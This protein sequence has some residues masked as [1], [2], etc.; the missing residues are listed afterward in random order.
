MYK[1]GTM[2]L[3]L[4]LLCSGVLYE[5]PVSAKA[6]EARKSAV[7][8]VHRIDLARW[9]IRN[10]GTQPAQATKGIND[11]LAWAGK[12][13]ITAVS[14]PPG[15]YAI[16][17]N[18]RINMVSNMTFQLTPDVILQKEPN[19]KERYDLMYIGYGVHDVTLIGGTYQGDKDM[20]DYSKKDH[21]DSKGTHE[22]GYG[23]L[24][25]G[26]ER[27][28]I[29]GVKAVNFTGDG[30]MLSAHGTNTGVLDAKSFVRG[31]IDSKGKPISDLTKIRTKSLKSLSHEIFRK[32]GY[33]ELANFRGL[34]PNFDIYFYETS[35][36]FLEKR[37]AKMRENMVIPQGAAFYHVVFHQPSA[38]D[39]YLQVWNRVPTSDSVVK[40]SEFAFNRR[41]G[42]TVGG[43]R[44]VTIMDN[45]LHD[46]KG[47]APQSGIDVEGGF[48][49]NGNWNSDVTIKRN[50][51]YNNAAYDL[52]LYDGQGA[53]V[54]DN[55]F[56]ST[57]KFGL[58]VSAPFA[59]AVMVNNHFD[60]S[61]IVAENDAVFTGN[62]M[63]DSV[64]SFLGPNIQVNGMTL[65][66]AVF[67][68]DGKEKFGVKVSELTIY[69]NKKRESGLIVN[70]MPSEFRNVKIIGESTLRVLTG[71]APGGSV[72]HNL[73]VLDYNSTYG[74]SLP[75]GT[76]TDCRFETA[77]TGTL[78][79]VFINTAGKY[80]FDNC[81]FLSASMATNNV[82][83]NH[84]ELDLS[85]KNSIFEVQGN[86]PAIRVQAVKKFV[87]ENNLVNAFYLDNTDI[88]LIKI[89]DYSKRQLK[90]PV[91][92]AAIRGNTIRS[93]RPAAGISTINAGIGAPVYTVE[94]NTLH[95][96]KLAL[97]PNDKSRNN[98]VE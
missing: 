85:I 81:T 91:R 26:A 34:P 33:F 1:P 69:N 11:A 27:V 51:F 13:G 6:E 43:T 93:N 98:Q 55:Y 82:I 52:I 60:G 56:G 70:G 30:L 20:H 9:G 61:K 39:A 28:T 40:N 16:D 73:Q 76:Y 84:K 35:G 94:N 65:T 12:A 62:K 95:T 45:I 63:N 59:D 86:A 87:F 8:P 89:N 50:R 64:A 42:I 66:D 22:G 71:N 14:L 48:F 41:Q 92:S 32:E 24:L 29:D 18:S 4:L 78:G 31:G 37:S 72:F 44:N 67:R 83:A 2:A 3:L 19:D 57:N 25:E 47:T 68:V 17:K 36:G 90:A 58:A 97:K 21:P 88:E 54:E 23:I 77:D 80:V 38:A 74:L 7:Q 96:A 49:E 10:D 46:M 15:T 53:H 5:Q 75:P 79:A